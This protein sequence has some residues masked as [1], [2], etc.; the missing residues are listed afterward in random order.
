VLAIFHFG[1]VTNF[2]E[3]RSQLHPLLF[4]E[5]KKVLLPASTTTIRSR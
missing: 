3:R 4:G 1:D 2:D 5:K